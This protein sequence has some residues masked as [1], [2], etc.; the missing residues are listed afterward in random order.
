MP[1]PWFTRAQTEFLDLFFPNH[2]LLPHDALCDVATNA[3]C[4]VY[5]SP[6]HPN[7]IWTPL[8]R[9]KRKRVSLVLPDG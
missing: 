8:A 9:T 2:A 4:A 3:F 5:H 1:P 7:G 6:Y